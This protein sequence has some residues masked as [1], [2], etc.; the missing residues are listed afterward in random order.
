MIGFSISHRSHS[1]SGFLRQSRNRRH[2]YQSFSSYAPSYAPRQLTNSLQS[3][4]HTYHIGTGSATVQPSPTTGTAQNVPCSNFPAL[5][6]Y[7]ASGSGS[8]ECDSPIRSNRKFDI[9]GSL[10]VNTDA[11]NASSASTSGGA[12]PSP[13]GPSTIAAP[14]NAASEDSP[15]P[16]YAAGT[17]ATNAPSARWS[18]M[19]PG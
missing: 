16:E 1:S 8:V 6:A 13:I 10:S 14:R 5:Y 7:L 2:P 11:P 9:C 3:F 4:S 17:T 19:G 18:A 12:T 15:D